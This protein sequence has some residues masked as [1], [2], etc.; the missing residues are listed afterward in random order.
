M[1][2]LAALAVIAQFATTLTAADARTGFKPHP[3]T[4][5]F[6]IANMHC[7]SCADLITESVRRVPGV[8]RVDC[9][10][11]DGHVLIA[12]DT[13]VSSY[14]QI[15]QAIQ[16][17]PPVHGEKYEPTL[18]FSVPAY[19]KADNAA[20]VDAVFAKRAARVK[21]ELRHRARGEFIL[22][23]LP[24]MA[25]PKKTGPQGWNAGHFGHAIHDAPPK[26]LGLEFQMARMNTAAR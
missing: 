3:I 1:K 2:H 10:P 13:H 18:R 22:H 12:F 4:A 20:K 9:Q 26:G 14:H 16:D 21:V 23:F 7:C 15:A 8:S 24:L 25:D 19:A 5:T 17:T 11:L 6:F